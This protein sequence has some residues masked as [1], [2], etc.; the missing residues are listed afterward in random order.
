MALTLNLRSQMLRRN[1]E[2]R[3]FWQVAEEIA[4]FSYAE[5]ALLL[6]DVWNKHWSHGANERLAAM[7]PRMNSVVSVAR[8]AG[9]M[10]I[11]APSSTMD[12]YEDSLSRKR[13]INTDLVSPPED[14]AHE[15]PPLPI[16][17]SDGGSDTKDVDL[18]YH[19][20]DKDGTAWTRQHPGIDIDHDLDFISDDG[21]QIYSCMHKRGVSNLLILGVHTNMCVLGRSFAIRQMVRWGKKV[22]LIRDLTDA[23]YDPAMPPYVSHDEGTRL[24]IG[25]IEKFWCPTIL[26]GDILALEDKFSK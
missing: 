7:L 16:D 22:A 5:T 2:N 26:S 14:I 12:F 25:Y 11:H 17:S 20:P 19:D 3:S 10:I 15:D 6:C 9:V 13:V 4:E 1:S 21:R 23:M 8:K 18:Q 24:V